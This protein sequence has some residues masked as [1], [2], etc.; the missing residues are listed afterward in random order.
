MKSLLKL[1]EAAQFLLTLYLYDTTGTSW[2]W[3]PLL[4]LLPDLSMLGYLLGPATGAFTYN[5]VHHKGIALVLGL[6]GWV[7]YMPALYLCGILLYSHSSLDRIFGYGLKYRDSFQH[8]H[9]GRIGE[10]GK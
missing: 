7:T 8:T 1:E 5:L 10:K 4:I 9:L 2:W 6:I 3:F